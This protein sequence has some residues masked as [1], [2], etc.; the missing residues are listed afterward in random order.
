MLNLV[1]VRSEVVYQLQDAQKASVSVAFLSAGGNPAKVDGKPAWTVSNPEILDLS[2]SEDGLTA[3]V[4][5]KGPV[6]SCQ[7]NVTAD[8]DLGEGVKSIVGQQ[9]VDVVAGEAAVVNISFGEAQPK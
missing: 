1:I 8:A 2:V 5:A 3:T 6:G 4:T 7:L 9:Q